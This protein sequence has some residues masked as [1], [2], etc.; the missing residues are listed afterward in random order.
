[1]ERRAPSPVR[2]RSDLVT[3][4]PIMFSLPPMI[5]AIPPLVILIPAMLPFGVQISPPVIGVATVL[6]LVVNRSVQ[7]CLRFLDGMLA[8]LLF[9]FGVRARCCCHE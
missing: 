8:L 3:F 5:F 7:S 4:L 9:G 2:P 6:A 1:V